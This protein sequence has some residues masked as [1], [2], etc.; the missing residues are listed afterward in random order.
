MSRSRPRPRPDFRI[1]PGHSELAAEHHVL[2][3]RWC[4]CDASVPILLFGS[5]SRPNRR[6]RRP[7][8]GSADYLEERRGR[9]HL[10]ILVAFVMEG[11][12]DT[13][14]V[15]GAAGGITVDP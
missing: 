8:R 3:S 13:N 12:P 10:A 14:L 5:L 7:V 6:S 15:A 4:Y 9:G 11:E 2:G 1:Q